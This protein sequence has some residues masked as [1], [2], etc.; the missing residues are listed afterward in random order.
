MRKE[1]LEILT[2]IW[3]NVGKAAGETLSNLTSFCVR[4][5]EEGQR[6][7]AKDQELLRTKW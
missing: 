7:M 6:L 1:C 3:H 2:L 5:A 4:I